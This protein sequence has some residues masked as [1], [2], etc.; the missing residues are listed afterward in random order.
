MTAKTRLSASVKQAI[1]NP[2]RI[3]HLI[4]EARA[5]TGKTTTLIE[6]L[7]HLV[8]METRI[9]PSPQQAEIWKSIMLSS[10][11]AKSICFVA[12]NKSI[13]TELQSRIPTGMDA[14]TLHSLGFKAVQQ[15]YGRLK[16]N[17]YRVQNIMERLLG[18]D[19]REVRK[20]NPTLV[21]SV[22]DLVARCKNLLISGESEEDLDA[23]C[24]A[25]DYEVNG[26]R[27]E[28]Y[29]LVPQVL[30]AC[31]DPTQDKEIDF[32][33]MVWLPVINN[34][35]VT[36]YDLL[37]VD[38]SQDLNRC[39]QELAKKA[40]KRLVFCGDPKQAIYGF[41]GAD[42]KSMERLQEELQATPEGCVVLPLTVT[43][44]CGKAIVTEANKYVPDFS[45]HE[46]NPEGKVSKAKYQSANDKGTYHEQCEAGD[47]IV[48][49][50]NAPLVSQCFK[51]LRQ[52]RKANIQGRDIGQ[53]LIRTIQKLK[54]SDVTDLCM[55]LQDSLHAEVKKENIKMQPSEA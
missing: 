30:R 38:E 22:E 40:G 26:S 35:Q 34:L 20:D 10:Q 7:K 55:K 8:G 9:Q 25:Y 52:N 49:R 24:E 42:A 54:A 14:M 5:G 11:S 3:P 4:I 19:I 29:K 41:A 17:S 47:M 48:C 12:F 23:I 37:L 6:G 15:A 27:A 16:V 45:A 32:N 31:L 13:A 21:K 2:T 53:G 28:I 50:V 39:Q 18:K 43:R 46:N 36:K 33:D 44:R 1:K 51:F